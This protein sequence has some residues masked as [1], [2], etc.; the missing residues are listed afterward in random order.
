M[1]DR[2]EPAAMLE[3]VAEFLRTTIVRELDGA[4]VYQAR[5]A[6]NL[7]Q[8]V[9]RQLRAHEDDI[10]LSDLADRIR[11][12]S[13]TWDTPEIATLLWRTTLAKLAVDQ[14]TYPRLSP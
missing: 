7:V 10:D 13:A 11:D 6:A 2:P 12:G 14:P 1:Y 8:I 3:S 9:A 5:I 4:T